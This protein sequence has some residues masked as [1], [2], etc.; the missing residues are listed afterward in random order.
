MGERLIAPVKPFADFFRRFARPADPIRIRRLTYTIDLRR[1]DRVLLTQEVRWQSRRPAL[2]GYRETVP[3]GA[4]RID[5]LWVSLGVA[6]PLAVAGDQAAY[7]IDLPAPVA[8]PAEATQLIS[9]ILIDP[10]P[11]DAPGLTL[12]PLY[13]AAAIGLQIVFPLTRPPAE[14]A[15]LDLADPRH[16]PDA[17]APIA[18]PRADHR[19]TYIW[20]KAAPPPGAAYRLTWRWPADPSW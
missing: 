13:P 5:R 8:A 10:F 20:Q 9:A 4:G 15:I 18:S 2:T 12:R 17:T 7:Q 19:V 11:G 6:R 16:A 1:S 3:V 14:F